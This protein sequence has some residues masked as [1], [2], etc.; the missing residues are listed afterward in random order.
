VLGCAEVKDTKRSMG[1]DPADV[2]AYT[3]AE[4]AALVRV[5]ASTLRSWV[6][7]R[8]IPTSSGKPRRFAPVI[9][10]ADERF[11]SFTN[12]VEAHV[13]AALRR[14]HEIELSNIR[15]AV[16]Y[17]ETKL[18]VERPLARERFKTD[19]V[20]LFVDRLG[21][22]INASR[23]GQTAMREVLDGRLQRVEYEQ[24]RAVRFF[25]LHRPDAPR[26]VV[27]DPHR[28]FGRPVIDGTS[29]P[30]AELLSR[31]QQGDP[32]ERLA[33]DFGVPE[34]AIEEAIR[35]ATKAA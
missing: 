4:A 18:G 17:V 14:E 13:L 2:P 7:G 22:L 28:A 24:D 27:V 33:Q 16:R 23:D 1:R 32:M 21:K 5:P 10:P 34:A 8:S 9:R 31:F 19:G 26:V 11:L 25:P 12:V 30:I 3:V 6:H 20:D 15:S 29:V 35:A